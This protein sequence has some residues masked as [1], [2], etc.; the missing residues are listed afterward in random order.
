MRPVVLIVD[1]VPDL[2]QIMEEAIRMAM[3]D[4]HVRTASSGFQA[5]EELQEIEANGE[6]LTLVLADQSLGDRQGLH[7]LAEAQAT[8]ARLVLVTGR[9]TGA[10][11]REA[12]RLG[13][14]VLWKPFRLQALLEML[15]EERTEP[16]HESV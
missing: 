15:R 8:G 11:E 4:H 16:P 1:D 12:E 7:V 9:A 5:R 6:R 10:V 14:T 3:P 2:L 13:A